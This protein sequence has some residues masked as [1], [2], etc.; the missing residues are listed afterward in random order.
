MGRTWTSRH[1]ST[2]R[3]V[4]DRGV[5]GAEDPPV[6]GGEEQNRPTHYR[7]W[8]PIDLVIEDP[9]V[10][11]RAERER[12]DRDEN[13]NH[14]LFH[15]LEEYQRHRKGRNAHKLPSVDRLLAWAERRT[16]IRPVP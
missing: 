1:R 9:A 14:Y 2:P 13:F 10:I 4:S 11:E 15:L 3:S 6:E 7:L 5:A 16:K 8:F 12:A